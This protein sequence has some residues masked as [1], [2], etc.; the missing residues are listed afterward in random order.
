MFEDL[1]LKKNEIFNDPIKEKK[2]TYDPLKL[3]KS[4]K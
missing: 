2:S 3:S 1:H 4:Y